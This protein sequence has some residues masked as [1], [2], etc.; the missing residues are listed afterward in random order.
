MSR[1]YWASFVAFDLYAALASSRG[2]FAQ[3]YRAKWLSEA[4]VDASLEYLNY[5]YGDVSLGD[6]STAKRS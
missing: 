4:E 5:S 3:S 1:F 2:L 6:S